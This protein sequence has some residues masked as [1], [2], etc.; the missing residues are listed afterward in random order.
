MLINNGEHYNQTHLSREPVVCSTIN[1]S[2]SVEG[3]LSKS[4]CYA[5]FKHIIGAVRMVS[6]LQLSGAVRMVSL[7]WRMRADSV[8]LRYCSALLSTQHGSN[9]ICTCNARRV[10]GGPGFFCIC[11][12]KGADQLR[13]NCAAERRLFSP[14]FHS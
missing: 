2:P 11:E 10:T 5:H 6:L 13:G 4:A 12:N 7:T 3:G 1:T 8:G 9:I 14:R